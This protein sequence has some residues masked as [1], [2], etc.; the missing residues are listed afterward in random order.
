MAPMTRALS[1]LLAFALLLACDGPDLSDAGTVPDADAGQADAPRCD[2]TDPTLCLLPWPSDYFRQDGRIALPP[3]GT[4][5]TK[6]RGLHVDPAPFAREGFSL[7]PTLMTVVTPTPDESSLF[8]EEQ[9]PESLG[10]DATAILVNVATGERVP[11]FAELD[12]WPGIDP[13][14]TPLYIRPAQ[15]LD[16]STRYAVGLRGLRAA[17]EAIEPTPYFRA[18]RDETP[19]EGTDVE[20]RHG[21]LD[22]VFAALE[23]AG[24]P[25]DELQLAWGFTTASEAS[26]VGDLLAMRDG[27]QAAESACTITS[28]EDRDAGDE[29]PDELWRRM[30]GTVRVPLYLDDVDPGSVAT[31][32]IA[33]DA[34]GRPV[35]AESVEVP[36]TALIP[37]SLRAR[38]AEDGGEPGRAIV[39]GHGIFG[40]QGEANSPWMYSQASELEAAVFATDWWG[41]SE[42]DLAGLIGALTRDFA[43][44]VGTT[45]RL[46]QGILN[47]LALTRAVRERCVTL[48]ELSVPLD[49]ETLAP[50]YDPAQVYFY[51]NSLGAI[52]GAVVAGVAP[53]LER[54]VL[55]VGGAVWPMLMKRS[56]AWRSFDGILMNIYEDPV[57]RALLI[58]MSGML[59]APVDGITY[60]PHVLRDPL[61]GS[62]ARR[63]LLQ[64]GI[65]DVA[66]SNAT[67]H[68]YAR[69]AGLPLTTPSLQEPFGLE[70]VDPE[71]ETAHSGLT[72]FGLEGIDPLPPG[73]RDPGPDTPTHNAVRNFPSARAQIDAFLQ[74]EGRVIHPCDGPCNPD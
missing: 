74:P 12:R 29:L 43:N 28:I 44:F 59:W 15:R 11:C 36:F 63:V 61:E 20:A 55:G 18:L 67:A 4:P 41:M 72:I 60:A 35:S 30:R 34:E 64:I 8:G 7:L 42:K 69:S 23:G 53:E 57:D 16:P 19:L 51:G 32:R 25:R 47:V 48:P 27:M 58:A 49:D 73:S 38:I 31:A 62:V 56:D 9:I 40:S 65:G 17:G 52:M 13:E 6:Q 39:Y 71:A 68:V 66:V 33:R 1:P 24:I 21:D 37:E 14:R 5:A 10:P 70:T 46:H 54:A 26:I 22:D 2:D 3:N 50:T 45:E